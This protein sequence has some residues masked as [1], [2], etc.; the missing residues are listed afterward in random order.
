MK[1]TTWMIKLT[2]DD[3]MS[4]PEHEVDIVTND[5]ISFDIFPSST[6]ADAPTPTPLPTPTPSPTSTPHLTRPFR[7][8][9]PVNEGKGGET[10]EEQ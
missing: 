7:P 3:F 10:G 2:I 8:W 6:S 9:D 4:L 1:S 5:L